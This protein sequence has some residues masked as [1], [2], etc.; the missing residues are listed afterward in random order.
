MAFSERRAQPQAELGQ[1]LI[2]I[3][4]DL[5]D[6]RVDRTVR[7]E[8]RTNATRSR[9]AGRVG[10]ATLA[11]PAVCQASAG[12][13]PA[14][15]RVTVRPLRSRSRN[16]ARS[17]RCGD[18]SPLS[19]AKSVSRN[20]ARPGQL[21]SSVRA[22]CVGRMRVEHVGRG[23]A[24]DREQARADQAR[25]GA[26]NDEH[27]FRKEMILDRQIVQR[28]HV[29]RRSIERS[30]PHLRVVLPQRADQAREPAYTSARRSAN[31]HCRKLAI[32]R[33]H[34]RGQVADMVVRID[35]PDFG[36]HEIEIG[37]PALLAAHAA[38][39]DNAGDALKARVVAQ[40]AR[41]L[42]RTSCS[43]RGEGTRS[44][45]RPLQCVQGGVMIAELD[46]EFRR[47]IR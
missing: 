16:T 10:A 14:T 22:L 13:T 37:A 2:L 30:A 12:S 5:I 29:R 15:V 7:P 6:L 40:R 36:Q 1:G 9:V 38:C 8:P 47:S 35:A 43:R 27:A 17:A 26:A 41:T 33:H 45:R 11:A 18:A 19:A 31:Q 25:V 21:Q 4:R 3:R 24:V 39:V 44:R 28:R 23:H 42:R 20:G 34:R 46:V 32:D